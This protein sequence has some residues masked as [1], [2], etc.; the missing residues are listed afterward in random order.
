MKIILIFMFLYAMSYGRNVEYDFTGHVE[1]YM[2]R[3]KSNTIN[4]LDL[5]LNNDMVYGN[6]KLSISPGY[7]LVDTPVYNSVN[8]KKIPILNALYFNELYYS[9]KYKNFIFSIGLFPFRKGSFYEYS[10][11][12]VR[13]GIGLYTLTDVTLQGIVGT[14]IN[15]TNITQIGHVG[16]DSYFKSFKDFNK[17]DSDIT[18]DSYKDSGMNF[19][20]NKCTY[21]KWYTELQLSFMYQYVNGV[22][23]LDT[24]NYA[25]GISYDDRLDT[26]RTYY[27]I[28]AHSRTSGDNTAL[29]P[30]KV[31]YDD[32]QY[33]FGKV[34]TSGYHMLVGVKQDIDNFIYKKDLVFGAEYLYQ[35][36]GYHSLTVGRPLSPSSYGDIGDTYST[37]IGIRIDKSNLIKLRYYKYYQSDKTIKYGLTPVTT[38]AKNIKGPGN[39]S[40]IGLQWYYDF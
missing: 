23:I 8:K 15:G 24:D 33:H 29:S 10:F 34:K 9:Y 26:G 31:P 3:M 40:F 6:N 7:F 25:L 13:A 38:D 27:S 12:D 16:F 4:R 17:G 2:I 14:Y 5:V 35:S 39:H 36:A 11:N 30:F 37:Y 32:K 18:F 1:Y 20:I 21:G 19:L 22:R 28:I